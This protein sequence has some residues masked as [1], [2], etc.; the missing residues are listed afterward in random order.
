[1]MEKLNCLQIN[2]ARDFAVMAQL[3]QI[4]VERSID[5]AILQEP[6]GYRRIQ[7]PAGYRVFS[8]L[9]RHGTPYAAVIARE[10][11]C[12]MRVHDTNEE[13]GACISLNVNGN[14]V[15]VASVYCQWRGDMAPYIATMRKFVAIAAGRPMLLGTDANASSQTWHSKPGRSN[16]NR[17]QIRGAE[18]D[19][20]ISAEN[21]AVL[22]RPSE[23]Y[24]FIGRPMGRRR[25]KVSDVDVTLVNEAWTT[26]FTSWW[27]IV[28]E[29]TTSDHNAIQIDVTETV[30]EHLCRSE[31]PLRWNQKN[32]DWLEFEAAVRTE[33][34]SVDISQGTVDEAASTFGTAIHRVNDTLCHRIDRLK[35][36]N[37]WWSPALAVKRRRVR[38]ARKKWQVASSRRFNTEG[39]LAAAYRHEQRQ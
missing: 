3:Q 4:L 21:L 2:C 8:T 28:T 26:R 29:L 17:L 24:T 23:H 20:F 31:P 16:N 37:A 38:A 6:M 22:N 27:Q 12:P 10:T 32:I 19:L 35:A 15:F 14:D 11:L 25:R 7:A 36:K 39:A 9:G 13:N 30:E 34:E 1:M 33:M 18:L 5:V